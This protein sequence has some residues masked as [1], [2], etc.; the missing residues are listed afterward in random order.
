LPGAIATA[1]SMP[2]ASRVAKFMDPRL[3]IAI[4]LSLFAIGSWLL[5]SLNQYAGFWDIFWPR[6]LQ[7]LAL[8]FL[9]VPLTTSAL[10]EI[11]R[12]AMSNATGLYTLVRQLGGSLGIALLELIE[13]RREDSAQQSFAANVTLSNPMISQMMHAAHSP[14]QALSSVAG[15]VDL[16]A[17]VVAYDY[18]FRFCA[19]VFVVS[20][21][22]VL[23]LKKAKHN[24]GA[25]AAAVVE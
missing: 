23:L 17:T 22:T 3:E 16:S 20:I 10:S 12:A 1:I 4:G 11:S 13:T 7:G 2:I 5:G 19:I 14:M 6:N 9:F 18:V 24:A 25:A 15:M 21:P 8:G